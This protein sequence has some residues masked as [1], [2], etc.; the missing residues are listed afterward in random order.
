MWLLMLVTFSVPG[1]EGPLSIATLDWI[2]L[3]TVGTRAVVFVA[4]STVVV[5]RWHAPNRPG[6]LRLL[7]PLFAFAVWAVASTLWSPLP[8]VTLGQAFTTGVLLLL[9]AAIAVEWRDE[10]DTSAVSSG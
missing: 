1:R 5:R 7:W 2:A 9:A 6:I 4:L 3:L 8:A 10:S